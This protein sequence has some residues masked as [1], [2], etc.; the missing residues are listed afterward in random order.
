MKYKISYGYRQRLNSTIN[1]L[2]EIKTIQ[3][4]NLMKQHGIGYVSQMAFREL[5]FLNWQEDG[6]FYSFTDKGLTNTKIINQVREWQIK[7]QM[8]YM[9]KNEKIAPVIKFR[10]RKATQ[11]S[12]WSKLVRKV[13]SIFA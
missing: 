9:P 1:Y 2:R 10:K 12:L 4:I 5:G 7:Y 8:K 11:V 6:N 13:K 3:H